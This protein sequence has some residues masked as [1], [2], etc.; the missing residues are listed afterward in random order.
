MKYIRFFVATIAL[1]A[2]LASCDL[3]NK[4]EEATLDTS[5]RELSFTPE[6]GSLSVS[7]TTD[8]DWTASCSGEGFSVSPASGSGSG[9]LT[10]SATPNPGYDARTGKVTISAGGL[11]S[12]VS[13]VQ[14]AGDAITLDKSEYELDCEPASLELKVGSTVDF[15]VDSPVDW[16][17]VVSSKGLSESKV[18][19]SVAR[20][21]TKEIR[22]TQVQISGGAISKSVH[23]VQK[24]TTHFPQTEAEFE[25]S[26]AITEAIG[27]AVVSFMDSLTPEQRKDSAMVVHHIEEME[28][29]LHVIYLS[30]GTVSFMQRDSIW[31]NYSPLPGDAEMSA[32]TTGKAFAV[33]PGLQ[34]RFSSVSP[35]NGSYVMTGKSALIV[36]PYFGHN[37]NELA[38]FLSDAGFSDIRIFSPGEVTLEHFHGAYL[39]TFDFIMFDTHGASLA[40]PIIADIEVASIDYAF[41]GFSACKS[42]LYTGVRYYPGLLSS[43]ITMGIN[44]KNLAINFCMEEG[45]GRPYICATPDYIRDGASFD[46]NTFVIMD[47]CSSA[48]ITEDKEDKHR[49][50]VLAFLDSGAGVVSGF[51][52][53]A[54]SANTLPLTNRQV[55]LMAHGVSYQDAYLHLQSFSRV[56]DYCYSVFDAIG[57]GD[58]YDTFPG[59]AY[60]FQGL[61]RC[62]QNQDMNKVPYFMVAGYPVLDTPSVSGEGISLS[63]ESSMSSFRDYDWTVVTEAN[64]TSTGSWDLKYKTVTECY[65]VCSFDVYIDGEK[66]ATTTEK[67]LSLDKEHELYD[68]IKAFGTHECYVVANMRTEDELI[69]SYK[70]DVVKY[71]IGVEASVEVPE[72]EITASTTAATVFVYTSCNTTVKEKGLVYSAGNMNPVIGPADCIKQVSGTHT[73]N[74]LVA[75]TGLTPGTTYYAR[76]YIIVQDGSS[77]KTIYS[78][79]ASFTTAEETKPLISLSSDSVNY[80]SIDVGV[81]KEVDITIENTGNATLTISSIEVS[82]ESIFSASLSSMTIAPGTP[83]T[84]TT[85]FLPGEAKSYSGTITIRSNAGNLPAAVVSLSGVG[86]AVS[87]GPILSLST[88]EVDFGSVY[89][90]GEASQSVSI[91]NTGDEPLV[92]TSIGKPGF[93]SV[94]WAKKTIGVNGQEPLTLTFKPGSAT[95]YSG[96][97]VIYS[98]G[99]NATIV[100]RGSG[101]EKHYTAEYVDLGLSVKWATC[102]LGASSPEGYGDYFAWGETETKTDFGWNTYMWCNGS[103]NSLTKYNTSAMSGSV[104]GKTVLESGD[105]AA[106]QA[107]GGK[108]RMATIKEWEE[109]CNDKYCTWT[110]TTVNGVQGYRITSK[111]TGFTDNSIFLPAAGYKDGTNAVSVGVRGYY[112]SSSLDSSS[113]AQ[114]VEF[115]SSSK[116]TLSAIRCFGYPVRPVY[117]DKQIQ[118]GGDHEGTGDEPWN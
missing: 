27:E 114:Y 57:S 34:N 100:V 115:Y 31:A 82:D 39:N 80:G 1:L 97:V 54:F 24:P 70:S 109:L 29:V 101:K 8:L 105:D 110:W 68:K 98:N 53:T 103:S 87:V 42:L 104:D 56:Y 71:T 96:T 58:D 79:T 10:V 99:G 19:L 92:I 72:D 12:S 33:T 23:I 30:D 65:Y 74:F 90:N 69:A 112:W 81:G 113:S 55:R 16:V 25:A 28:N 106:S 93:L 21:D 45:K 43:L 83:A 15:Q 84:L 4:E 95:S 3:M 49:S 102:N 85:R 2:A 64:E 66:V 41:P 63:W 60:D 94:D 9:R 52:N 26:V 108:W 14:A 44:P 78:D 11:S 107:F 118:P 89:V 116:I 51:R 13:L 6:G 36:D 59:S 5:V 86:T 18:V 40:V 88:R 50:L 47:A 73:D 48:A 20:N 7:V 77:D 61:Y 17:S 67:T 91:S 32:Q 46:S 111:I 38:Q 62:F 22:E 117:G 75:L 35:R 37:H 76:G